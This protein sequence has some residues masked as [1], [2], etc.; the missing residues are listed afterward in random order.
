M[1]NRIRDIIFLFQQL[2]ILDILLNDSFASLATPVLVAQITMIHVSGI[3]VTVRLHSDIPLMLY[4]LIALWSLAFFV[5]EGLLYTMMGNVNYYSEETLKSWRDGMGKNSANG[6][7]RL[8]S[9]RPLGIR[10]GSIYVIH[11]TT[12]MYIFLAIANCT[13]QALLVL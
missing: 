12:V 8:R 5:V 4:G 11:R 10:V 7:K 13:V 6:R 1:K 2:Q 9:L 3:F